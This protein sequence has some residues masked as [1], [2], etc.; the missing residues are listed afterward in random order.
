MIIY[1]DRLGTTIGET[2]KRDAVVRRF[3]F[4]INKLAVP[5]TPPML[6]LTAPSGADDAGEVWEWGDDDSAG[7]IVGSCEEFCQVVTQT[8]N[9]QDVK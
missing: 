9:I 2:Q 4:G 5:P 7:S 3:C 6:R 8:R 1:Q